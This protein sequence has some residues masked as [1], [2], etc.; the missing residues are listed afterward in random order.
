MRECGSRHPEINVLDLIQS[1]Q[2]TYHINDKAEPHDAP[3]KIW[4]FNE[5]GELVVSG[6]GFGYVATKQSFKDY[7][8]VFE[9][10]FPGPTFG[11]RKDKARDNGLIIH[12]HGPDG[13]YAGTWM[14]GI[15]AQIIEGGTGDM[16]VL[17]G[18][19]LTART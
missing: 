7:H 3:D 12:G 15:E 10:K 6:R 4:T 9:F 2:V 8:L 18:S 5:D 17:S 1:G 16:L 11:N 19:C 14:S 13:A